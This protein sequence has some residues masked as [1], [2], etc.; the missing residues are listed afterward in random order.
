MNS[1]TI[2]PAYHIL[3]VGIDR[4][5]PGY[6][7][8]AGC[9]NDIDAVEALLLEP[10][11]VGIPPE[12]ISITRLIASHSNSTSIPHSQAQTLAPTKA[13]LI[14]ALTDLAGPAVNARTG[15]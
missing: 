2:A 11:G 10:P 8:L 6:N 5:P 13:N 9:V 3:L 14:Q 1:E 15:S 4:Y 7:S 12:Q